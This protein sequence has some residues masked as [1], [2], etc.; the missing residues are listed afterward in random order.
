MVGLSA[1]RGLVLILMSLCL[2][3][4]KVFSETSQL[5]ELKDA[6]VDPHNMLS[7]WIYFAMGKD[8][9]FGKSAPL[10]ELVTSKKRERGIARDI[11]EN[12]NAFTP[13]YWILLYRKPADN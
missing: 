12:C 3:S 5:L 11:D 9:E 1:M 4:G 10:G 7:R 2:I 6:I 8:W 13:D